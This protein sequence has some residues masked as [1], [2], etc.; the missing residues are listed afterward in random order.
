MTR[1]TRSRP[2]LERATATIDTPV[3]P[4]RITVAGGVV[5]AVDH[6]QDPP[7]EVPP[8]D[9]LL[10]KAIR[11]IEEYFAGKRRRFDLPMAPAASPFQ[12]RVRQAVIDIPY[13]EA[14][15][16][17]GVAHILNSGPRAVGQACG[18]ND[19]VLLVPCHRVI[20]AGGTLGGYGSAS[21]LE[22]KR[23][24]LEFEGYPG[25]FPSN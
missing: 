18:R 23:R 13:G 3:G 9:K 15:S 2:V 10:R 24:L 11:Q 21:G 25:K 8:K 14:A 17:G 5:A 7:D 4:V 19:L 20:G 16:Y 6:V 12:Q 1:A 22:R